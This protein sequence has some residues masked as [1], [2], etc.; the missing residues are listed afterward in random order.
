MPADRRTHPG[1]YLVSRSCLVVLP[2][3]A[4][5]SAPGVV[6]CRATRFCRINQ[7]AHRAGSPRAELNLTITLAIGAAF[8]CLNLIRGAEPLPSGL[9]ELRYE[10]PI[11]LTAAIYAQG[12]AN[13]QPLFNFKRVATRSGST[14]K[15]QRDFTYP[16]GKL[17]ARERVVYEGDALV[18]YELEE[19]QFG[20]A[21]SASLRRT[22]GNPVKETIEFAY[23]SELGG[24]TKTATETL[25]GDLLIGD[26]VAP[27][28]ASNWDALARGEE[29]KCRYIVVP[30]R[31]T[32]GFTFVKSRESTFQGK[33][34]M[35]VKMGV[36]SVLLAALVDPLYFTIEKAAPHHVLQYVGRTTPKIQSG[37]KW[38]DLDSVT[39]FD[40]A[41]AK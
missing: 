31:E 24:R 23:R 32:V 30:R 15:V 17:A 28:L 34:V 5:W 25:K 6:L 40:W 9:R 33:E 8:C 35:L 12:A 19:S 1:A 27:F 18:S 7:T 38:K 39:V 3:R 4:L 14:L 2:M 41:T 26:M 16:D 29:V 22:T 21:G 10:E 20:A 37:T 11:Y 13:Q 36:T